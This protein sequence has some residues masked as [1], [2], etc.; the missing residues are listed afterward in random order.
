MF[1]QELLLT[2]NIVSGVAPDT[3]QKAYTFR[4]NHALFVHSVLF[5]SKNSKIV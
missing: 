2:G 3:T 5:P 4:C 1:R